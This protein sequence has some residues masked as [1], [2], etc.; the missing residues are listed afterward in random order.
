MVPTTHNPNEYLADVREVVIKL[1]RLL[2]E[3]ERPWYWSL[4]V[5]I[6]MQQIIDLYNKPE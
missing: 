2:D 5:D 6:L 1:H 4:T 3:I